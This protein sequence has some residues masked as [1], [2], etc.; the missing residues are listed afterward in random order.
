MNVIG[1]GDDDDD[2]DADVFE[3]NRGK[4]KGKEVNDFAC[5]PNT[6]G[7]PGQPRDPAMQSLCDCIK[8]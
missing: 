6:C 1:R 4:G 3:K 2:E 7:H 8:M 5:E